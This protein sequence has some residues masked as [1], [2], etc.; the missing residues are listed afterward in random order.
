[1][2]IIPTTVKLLYWRT[3][4][5]DI[6]PPLS[7]ECS[8]SSTVSVNTRHRCVENNNFISFCLKQFYWCFPIPL[9]QML[10][11]A[12]VYPSGH[13]SPSRVL[14]S[15]ICQDDWNRW[16][17]GWNCDLFCD[18]YVSFFITSSWIN[19]SLHHACVYIGLLFQD[20]YC[21]AIES[22]LGVRSYEANG[23]FE[24]WCRVANLGNFSQPKIKTPP[25]SDSSS[26]SW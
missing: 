18:F 11:C 19:D 4:T 2:L 3:H 25:V 26:P 6:P 14:F 20:L 15:S 16:C 5:G 8:S 1:M 13:M 7:S 24:S 23:C 21:S 22:P 17:N 9:S 12:I 10:V